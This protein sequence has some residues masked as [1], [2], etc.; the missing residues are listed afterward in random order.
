VRG[1]LAGAGDAGVSV[2]FPAGCRICDKLLVHSCRVPICEE[3]LDSFA[4]RAKKKSEVCGQ[5]L[6]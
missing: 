4:A 2:V 3:C 5:A 6:E 1:W